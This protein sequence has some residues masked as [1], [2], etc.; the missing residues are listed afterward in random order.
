LDGFCHTDP[1]PSGPPAFEQDVSEVLSI[2][3]PAEAR[4]MVSARLEELF[5]AH[6]QRLY[7]LARRLLRDA[8]AARDAVQDTFLR[9][10]R[11]ADRLPVG[12]PGGEAWLVRV[13][14]NLCRDRFRRTQ[15]RG[16][17]VA[18]SG[19]EVS[20]APRA[21]A[22]TLARLSV[23]TALAALPARRRAV[24]VLHE[25]EER[26]VEEIAGLLGVARVTVR[27]H[28]AAGRKQLAKLLAPTVA[29]PPLI[30]ENPR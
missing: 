28:L 8:D 1:T 12:E 20:N 2:P 22:A 5:E 18:L 3:I 19:E 25:L 10:A 14:V 4:T 17:P 15:R 6:H 27:W 7:R 23:E 21:D 9:A 13:L 30:G 29:A 26:S 24:V 11:H 16:L